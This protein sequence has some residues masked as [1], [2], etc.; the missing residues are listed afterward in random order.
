MVENDK[1]KL[2]MK[3]RTRLEAE[4]EELLASSRKSS[5]DRAPVDDQQ[6]VG[7]LARMDAMQ[8]Q[9]MA[10]ASERRRQA[11]IVNLRKALSRLAEGEYGT[12]E[13]CGEAIPAG[14]LDVDATA[15]FCV[16]CAEGKER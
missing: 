14:R 12:C 10:L 9:A 5:Q 15:R 1:A 13:G 11:R 4:L 2:E 6:S 16:A 7:R 8:I 3:W